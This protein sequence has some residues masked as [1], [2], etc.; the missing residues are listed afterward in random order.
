MSE[1][2][3]AA[4]DVGGRAFV[5]RHSAAARA[6]GER[7][8]QLVDQPDQFADALREGLRELVDPASARMLRIVSPDVSVEFAVRR[9]LRELI[10]RP[11]WRS[12]RESSSASSLWLAQRLVVAEHR[13]LRLFALL[14]MRRALAPDPELSWQL[15]RRMGGGAGDWIEVDALADLWARGILAEPFR[16]A[17]LEQLVYSARSGE[18]RLVGATLANIP[19]RVP[20]ARRDALRGPSSERAFDLVRMLMG[21]AAPTVQKALSWALREWTPVDPEGV[22]SL[23]RTEALAARTRGDGA[24]AWVIRETLARQPLE[25][26]QELRS[27]LAGL[28]RQPTDGSTSVAATVSAQWS[29]LPSDHDEVVA[30]QGDRYARSRA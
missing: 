21:D 17:E 16:W 25:L 5:T 11:V 7:L 15:M 10:E 2:P 12:L 30:R 13:D 8:A 1:A 24:R 20:R 18:R 14:P 29:T 9:P 22:A 4:Q 26:A 23:L 27:S 3:S 6:L 19:H 28:R